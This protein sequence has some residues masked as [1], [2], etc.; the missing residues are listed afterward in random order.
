MR[1]PS[2]TL[3]HLDRSKAAE[4]ADVDLAASLEAF[5][6]RVVVGWTRGS[7]GELHRIGLSE[8]LRN[9]HT[10]LDYLNDVLEPTLLALLPQPDLGGTTRPTVDAGSSLPTIRTRLRPPSLAR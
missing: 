6:S 3:R 8:G 2:M 4:S 5:L 7:V 1:S 9:W 10:A